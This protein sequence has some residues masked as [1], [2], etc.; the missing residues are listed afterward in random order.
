VH[1]NF[2]TSNH[3]FQEYRGQ[4]HIKLWPHEARY[5]LIGA[6][7]TDAGKTATADSSSTVIVV[8][9]NYERPGTYISNPDFQLAWVFNL[10]SSDEENEEQKEDA[11]NLTLRVGLIDGVVGGGFDLDFW[12][13]FRITGEIRSRKNEK[14]ILEKVSPFYGRAYLSMRLFKYFRVY[15]GADNFADQAVLSFGVSIEWEDKDIK[16]IVGIAGAAY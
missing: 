10:G 6:T 5:F 8:D 14:R 11:Y 16:S 12:R 13:H 3:P 2:F 9:P 7:F 15:A 4:V 1:L